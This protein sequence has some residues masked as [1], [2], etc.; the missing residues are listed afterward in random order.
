MDI[1]TRFFEQTAWEQ[2]IFTALRLTLIVVLVAAALFAARVLLGRLEQRLVR[3]SEKQ[4]EL[5]GESRKR[6][7]TLVRLVR[8]AA[9]IV[10][11]IMGALVLLRELGIEITPILAS[12]GIASLAV[13]FGAQNLVRDVIAGFFM[14]LENQVRVG[15]VAN[16][17]GTGGLV[18]QINFRTIVL[19]DLSGTVHVFPN[20]SVT[21]LANLTQEWSAAVL[22]I[23]V[24][25]KEDIDRV[26]EIMRRIGAELR[27]DATFGPA[28]IADMEIFGVD[29]FAD[30]A[31][32]IKCRLK[33]QP[34]R[35]WEIGRE[36]R[37][38]LKKAFDEA[39]VEIPFPHRTLY[40][41]EQQEGAL[42]ALAGAAS[43]QRVQS[44][45]SG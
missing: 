37:R 29:N 6:A 43:K 39:G 18:E 3:L 24:A 34:I 20:G 26:I 7:E 25:Y 33:T 42:A 13:G 44:P 41:G 9:L 2:L 35:Q 11:W 31:I 17:N 5:P 30:S 28:I 16:V 4:G 12:V 23:G 8:Q 14:I 27:T 15:D 19:R 32:V 1:L 21:T 22:D 38:R 36:Y 40:F 10:I 45:P